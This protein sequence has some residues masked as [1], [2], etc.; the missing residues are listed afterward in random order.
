MAAHPKLARCPARLSRP[1]LQPLYVRATRKHTNATTSYVWAA[2]RGIMGLPN[3]MST[4]IS[5]RQVD[6]A[7]KK[8]VRT[9]AERLRACGIMVS[10]SN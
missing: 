2:V 10:L 8:R 3:D 1:Q 9:F 7:Q 4:F 6:D 5:Y